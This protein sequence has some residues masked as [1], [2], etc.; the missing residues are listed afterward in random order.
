M[1]SI[2]ND[3]AYSLLISRTNSFEHANNLWN[4]SNNALTWEKGWS[5]IGSST[6]PLTTIFFIW[7][8]IDNGLFTTSQA[9]YVFWLWNLHPLPSIV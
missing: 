6:S 8:I 2:A 9:L 7:K 1:F 3:K 5:L 4:Q